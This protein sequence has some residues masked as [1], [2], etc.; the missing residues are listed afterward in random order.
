MIMLSIRPYVWG[1]IAQAAAWYES[2]TPGV[3]QRFED[4]VLKCLVRIEVNPYQF[5]AGF[6]GTRK[7]IVD[8]FPFIVCYRI[9]S[10]TIDVF[11]VVHGHRCASTWTSLIDP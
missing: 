4:A 10:N 1:H 7:G 3:G 9:L 8:R 6:R 2:Q 5:A 11:C